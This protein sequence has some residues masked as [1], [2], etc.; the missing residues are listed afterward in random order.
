[1]KWKDI[2][3]K[4]KLVLYIVTGVFLIL[5]AST[6][7][8]ITT[9]TEQE[10][11]LAYHDSIQNAKSFA[12]YYNADM[13]A[14]MAVAQTLAALLVRYDNADRDEINSM[15]EEL[16]LENPDLL[17]SYVA[18][19]PNAFDGKD[20]EFINADTA[21]DETGRF[22]PYWNKIGGEM[23]VEPLVDYDTLDYYQL[24]KQL[25][26]DIITEPYLY[27]GALIVSY[28]A[29][30]VRDGEFIGIGG[31]D[32][33]LNYVDETVSSVKAFDT[34]YLFM[35]S[36]T[37]VLLSHPTRKDWIGMK[38]MTEFEI[39]MIEIVTED[40][41]NGIGGH[42]DT[43]DPLTGKEVVMFY[44]PIE[45]GKFAIVLVVPTEEML[46]GVES[47]RSTLI[48]IYTFSII[49]MGA[50]AYLIA[51]SFTD[52]INEIVVDFKKISGAAIKGDLNAR[53]NTDVEI[54]FKLI[55]EGMNEI[56]DALTV[57]SKELQNS[58]ELIRKMESAVNTSKVVVFWWKFDHDYPVE[59]VSDNVAQFGYSLENFMSGNLLY[60]NIIYKDDR[61][62]V[63]SELKRSADEGHDHFH[64]DYR[65]ITKSGEMRWVHED[66]F[67]QRN[68]EEK[69]EYFQGTILDITERVEAENALKE[70]EE[71]R[72]KE[73]HHRIKNN[74]QV[75][76]GMLYLESL[77]FRYQEVIDAFRDSENRVRSIALIH[78]KLYQSKDLVSLDLA[79]YIKDLT[80]HLFHS[81]RIDEKNIELILN[82]EDV[83]LGMDTAVPLGI[84]INELTSNALQHAFGNGIGGEIEIDFFK[85]DEIFELT[86]SNTGKHFPEDIDFK[87]TESLGL[88]LVTNLVSQIEGEIGLDTTDKTTF[89]ITFRDD[90]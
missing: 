64:K 87:N 60:G 5:S 48:T 79:D 54:D 47:L 61:D 81:Y 77:N 53:A 8:V 43:I 76:S 78:E 58:Y 4:V 6:F 9:V 38:S 52:R 31:V 40:I 39:P 19:E 32:V 45:T 14:N 82:V 74:L 63:W 88:Q 3:L 73:I 80:D 59:F 17:A 36:N 90:K 70:M 66:T 33:E 44:E 75:V 55:P 34:G 50:M 85:R 56:M 16:L 20:A 29:P 62:E 24:T 71:I 35:V 49:F 84:I 15:L 65:I 11:Q 26:Q 57:H 25:E 67:I 7:I 12:N 13:K 22:I 37:G 68:E 18:F 72:T 89:T 23:F 41:N 28:D 27:Q 46:A 42:I 1:M 30:I 69:V 10:E 51:A 83:F 86:I 21:H 2:S